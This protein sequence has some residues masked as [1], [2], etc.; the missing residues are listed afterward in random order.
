MQ[1]F[2]VKKYESNF[3]YF[4]QNLINLLGELPSP[5]LCITLLLP[6]SIPINFRLSNFGHILQ[7]YITKNG[8]FRGHNLHKLKKYILYFININGQNEGGN[9]IG[10]MIK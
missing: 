7:I 4:V 8:L 6:L 5:Q 1:K 3:G 10:C 2:E 9:K